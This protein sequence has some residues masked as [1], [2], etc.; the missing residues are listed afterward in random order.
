MS[1]I[2]E[3]FFWSWPVSATS[4]RE[5]WNEVRVLTAVHYVQHVF[6]RAKQNVE[7]ETSGVGEL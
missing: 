2:T 1:A 7:E 5:S 4:L 3:Y 6:S